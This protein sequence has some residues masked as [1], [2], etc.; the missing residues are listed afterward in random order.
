MPI[1]VK[2]GYNGD[3]NGDGSI[4]VD[5]DTVVDL[6][7]ASSPLYYMSLINGD[8]NHDGRV[9]SDDYTFTLV[10]GLLGLIGLLFARTSPCVRKL[11]AFLGR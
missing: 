2:S 4:T 5:D 11:F 7:V 1:V 10:L 3:K 8:T 9:T 6:A